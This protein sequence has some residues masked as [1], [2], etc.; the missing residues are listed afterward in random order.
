M[1]HAFRRLEKN[2]RCCP[3]HR[4]SRWNRDTSTRGGSGV[5]KTILSTRMIVDRGSR[6]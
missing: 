2:C 6:H 4:C 3:K 1:M 5:Q